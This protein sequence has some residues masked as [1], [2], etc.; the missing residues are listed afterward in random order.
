MQVTGS[1]TSFPY[2]PAVVAHKDRTVLHKNVTWDGA[3][4]TYTVMNLSRNSHEIPT[5]IKL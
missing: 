3:P 5:R 2:T 4:L 1:R